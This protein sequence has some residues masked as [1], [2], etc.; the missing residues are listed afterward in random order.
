LRLS[1]R[2]NLL[3]EASNIGDLTSD[4]HLD[5]QKRID[6]ALQAVNATDEYRDFTEKHRFA[7]RHASAEIIVINFLPS[8]IVVRLTSDIPL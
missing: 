1:N 3:V 8:Q 5:I 2:K 7:L 4:K 6:A